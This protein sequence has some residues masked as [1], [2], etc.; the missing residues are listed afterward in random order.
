LRR[1][2]RIAW[3]AGAAVLL[4]AQSFDLRTYSDIEG[5]ENQS[6][7]ALLQDRAG[8]LWVGTENG[9][10]RFDGLIFQPYRREQGLPAAEIE[11]LHEAADGT[12]W[13]GTA[14]GL[15]RRQG[16][17]FEKV[18]MGV[19]RRVRQGSGIASDQNGTLYVATERGLAIGRPGAGN[20]WSFEIRGPE[21]VWGVAVGSAGQVWFGCNQGLCRLQEGKLTEGDPPVRSGRWSA[22]LFDLEENLWVHSGAAVLKVTPATQ[23][24]EELAVNAATA[25]LALDEKGGLIAT[26]AGGVALRTPAGW[27]RVDAAK[28]LPA[29]GV[30]ALLADREGSLWLG[31]AG[32]G[33]ARWVGD[34]GWRTYLRGSAIIALHASGDGSLWAATR[35]AALRGR[36]SGADWAFSEAGAG[37][38]AAAAG[39]AGKSWRLNL[40]GALFLGE[41]RVAA[42]A[43][44]DVVSLGAGP[45]GEAWIATQSALY[46]ASEQ[47]VRRVAVPGEEPG[48]SYYAVHGHAGRAWV[49]SS[50]GLLEWD[51]GAWRRHAE[52]SGLRA[53]AVTQ[54]VAESADSVWVAYRD[55]EGVS[56]LQRDGE[57]FRGDHFGTGRGLR[58]DRVAFLGRDR[59]G[60]IW[61]GTDRGVDVFD[62]Q[63]WRHYGRSDGLAADDCS[64]GAFLADPDGSVWIGT[65]R[66]VSHFR[67]VL[68]PAAGRPSP[69]VITE[70]RLGDR[71]VDAG[72]KARAA[73]GENS[74]TVRFAALT[75][76]EGSSVVYRY[77]LLPGETQW[78]ET[79]Q[80]QINYARL[81]PGSYRLE[82]EAR[83]AQG[84]WS[85][86]PARLEFEI[87][88]AWFQ[89]WWFR[90]GSALVLFVILR[91][92]ALRRTKLLERERARLEQAVADRTA[93]LSREKERVEFE[94]QTV[95]Q[96]NR[97]IERLLEDAQQASR[98]KSEFLANM[99][100]EI[101]TPMNGIMG[102]T[103]L[104]LSTELT[105]EQ[106]DYLQTAKVS[107]DFLL[108]ILNDV[109]D[110][111]KIESG[112]LELDPIPFSVRECVEQTTRLLAVNAAEKGLTL[113]TNLDPELPP[114]LVGDPVRLRQVLV[115]L[116][117]NA[118]KF[119]DR[120]LVA[121]SA[122]V[123]SLEETGVTLQFA[124]SDTGIGIP[125]DKQQ[126]IFEAFRQ[127]DGSTTRKFGGTGL[128]LAICRRLV[129]MMGGRIWVE[130]E[131]GAGSTF[132]FTAP[133]AWPPKD[134]ATEP[135]ALRN[136]MAVMAGEA[137]A[138]TPLRILL[139]E[140][141]PVNQKLAVRLLEKRG[142]QVQV[143]GT[144][145]EALERLGAG[146]YDIVLM[147]VQMPDMDG[148]EATRHIRAS[149]RLHGG[150]IPIVALT[151]H[152]MKGDRERCLAAGMDAFIDKPID[153]AKL[154]EVLDSLRPRRV[155]R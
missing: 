140:D 46:R 60:W 134:A 42:I 78:I 121:V 9:L 152:N 154:F 39:P 86:E 31:L 53:A 105:P 125:A 132:F 108:Q 41:Q 6:I 17:R 113:R 96:Q 95:E 64:P 141:N 91:L 100:H 138:D 34:R 97:E 29:D 45:G 130:S 43:A 80:R 44:D 117:G 32:A 98:M 1:T 38:R 40:S 112:R 129:E 69:V 30:T 126:V 11:A 37:F 58:S 84:V 63:R 115:N 22:L 139:A 120:G 143:A 3:L 74:L 110:F 12:L 145:R 57:G 65:R 4:S 79:T 155:A 93:E 70:V 150:R 136:M 48:D 51:G 75:F 59:R 89:Q 81:A 122:C 142:H 71:T 148:L 47:G 23:V 116:V 102:M 87:G 73:Y 127:A 137:P 54:V 14:G 18:P 124:V 27:E 15:A 7:R 107:A 118:L 144:G 106:R 49:A 88:Q 56:H 67:P 13:V 24:R 52:P 119:T 25:A 146:A 72:H 133:L 153:V 128:G 76:L 10:F 28:G 101:R 26:A 68:A 77:R 19:A 92:I 109:L 35:A 85:A 2:A 8:F 104:V 147:D 16:N 61:V 20:T 123:L 55:G 36:K 82:V 21:R 5:L 114:R 50:R 62:Q 135:G 103:N 90:L 111:S 99:S 151:A 131:I 83:N 33:L 149:E 94:K 66:G